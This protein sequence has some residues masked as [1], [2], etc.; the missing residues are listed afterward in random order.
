MEAPKGAGEVTLFNPV[1]QH[2][3]SFIFGNATMCEKVVELGT[4]VGKTLAICGAGP[5]LRENLGVLDECDEVWGVNSAAMWLHEHGHKVTHAFT[6]D[7]TPTQ[8]KEWV[9]APADLKY[10]LASTCHVHLTEYL[11]E[12]GRDVTFFH[13][14]VGVKKPPVQWE[15]ESGKVRTEPYEI[16]LYMT[17]YD[18]T[19]QAGNGL[20]GVPRAVDVAMY[21]GFERI[22]LLGADCAMRTDGKRLPPEIEAGSAEQYAWLAENTVFHVDGGSAVVNGQ[23]PMTFVGEID[24]RLWTTKPDL[25]ITAVQIAKWIQDG[26]VECIGDTFPNAIKDKD[27]AFFDRLP[28]L[29]NERG[30]PIALPT[31]T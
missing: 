15:D 20:N 26:T 17:L 5:S 19:V 30:E 13:S 2:F 10:M 21:Q 27:D 8:L 7:Q 11:A 28:K 4:S 1:A 31:G 3:E 18:G 16:W 29:N 22:I 9:S 23:S 24:G 25:A 6:I 14:F 12:L